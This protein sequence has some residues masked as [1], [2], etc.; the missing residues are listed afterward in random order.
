VA[1]GLVLTAGGADR[2]SVSGGSESPGTIVQLYDTGSSS[3]FPAASVAWTRNWWS[4]SA[5]LV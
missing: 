4:P 2:I 1:S 5:R 3:R